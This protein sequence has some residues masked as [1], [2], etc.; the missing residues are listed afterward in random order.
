MYHNWVA[1]RKTR[2]HWFLT[3]E[4]SLGETQC[5]K[6]WNQIKEYG[7]LSLRYVKRVSGERKDHRWENKC[8]SSSSAKSHAIK[9]EDRSHEETERQQRCARSKA[10]HL[11][12]NIYKLKEKTKLH[13]IF[14]RRT[15]DSRLRQ[16][17]EPEG[18][19]F[20]VDPGASMHMVIKRDLNSAE[21]ETE[22]SDDGDNGQR[23]GANQRR[24]DCICHAYWT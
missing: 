18:R 22:E 16:L 3:E 1:S 17:K 5:R 6:S 20:V 9:I 12:K 21:L 14:P 19:K 13:S 4:N 2:K 10:W 11:A 15:G 24:S 8:Q 23:R 7:S